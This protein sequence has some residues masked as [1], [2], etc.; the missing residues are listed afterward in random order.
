MSGL[1]RRPSRALQVLAAM[2]MAWTLAGPL[3]P[4][5]GQGAEQPVRLSI[6]PI[7]QPGQYFELTMAGGDTRRL[8]VALGNHG[9][10]RIVALS[11]AADAYTIYNGGFGAALRGSVPSASTRWLDYPTSVLTL[12][13][14]QAAVRSFT[15][16]VPKGTPAGEYITSVVIENDEP[17]KGSGQVA[18]DQIVR[19]AVAVAVRVPGPL[20]PGLAIGAASH[21]VAAD[22]SV[23]AV[24]VRNIGN[25]RLE[26]AAAL[27]IHDEAG[28][29]VS[30]ANVPM[31]SF[32]AHTDTKVEITLAKQL[33]PGRYTADLTL[34]DERR[35]AA[36][37][38]S[39]LPFTVAA[40]AKATAAPASVGRQV[41]DV[42]QGERSGPP[43]WALVVIGLGLGLIVV[44]TVALIAG[45]RRRVAA[46]QRRPGGGFRPATGPASGASD[47]V[48]APSNR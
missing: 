18:L 2:A 8:Q 47:P 43:G 13:P 12:Q 17:I 3:A 20:R 37:T 25:A 27:V 35:R 33:E 1:V 21:Q 7:S 11:Y 45:R 41:I 14:G 16:A 48:R 38:A 29:L 32:Y 26:P 19:Q 36:A 28:A 24:D 42:L 30:R 6:K 40:P 31:D 46:R 15:V 39:G 22:R 34:R 9:K 4:A 44:A 5:A 23:V 10:E